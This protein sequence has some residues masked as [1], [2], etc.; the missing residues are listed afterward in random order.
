MNAGFFQEASEPNGW[1]T[2][3]SELCLGFFDRKGILRLIVAILY[4][5]CI[6]IVCHSIYVVI[7]FRAKV[8]RGRNVSLLKIF[9]VGAWFSSVIAT[10]LVFLV[11]YLREGYFDPLNVFAILPTLLISYAASTVVGVPLL[12]WVNKDKIIKRL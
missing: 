11:F 7:L 12:L 2:N 1:T 9:F 3:V 6:A 4:T 10:L 5:V 8:G